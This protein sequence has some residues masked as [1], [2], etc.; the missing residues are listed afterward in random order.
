MGSSWL[1]IVCVRGW[2]YCQLHPK[3]GLPKGKSRR[4]H[5]LIL[6]VR[7][8]DGPRFRVRFIL[9]LQQCEDGSTVHAIS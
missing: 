1:G 5:S 2:S 9:Q 3:D 4:L 6:R 8:D 7:S